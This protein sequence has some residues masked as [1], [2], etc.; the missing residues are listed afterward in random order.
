MLTAQTKALLI[1]MML[2]ATMTAGAPQPALRD[3]P[4][5]RGQ[6]SEGRNPLVIPESAGIAAL[7]LMRFLYGCFGAVCIS[8]NEWEFPNIEVPPTCTPTTISSS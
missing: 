2:M 1:V 6:E 7:A 8:H 3:R 5:G 4:E